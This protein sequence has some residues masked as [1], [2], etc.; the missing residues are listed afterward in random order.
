MSNYRRDFTE[1]AM[2]FFTIVLLDRKSTL[3]TDFVGDF[4]EAY[5]EVQSYYPFETIAIVVLPD[6][7]HVIMQLPEGDSNYSRRIGAIKTN[8]SRRIQNRTD[9]T[10]SQLKK[11][12]SGI[13]QR[14]FWEHLI[15]DDRDLNNHIDYIYYNPVK[16]GYVAKVSDWEYSSFHRDVRLGFFDE[17]WGGDICHEI[18]C[19]DFE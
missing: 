3:L 7:F 12:E 6:H 18:S 13:W 9:K 11:R 8:F 17:D 10:A 19:L 15:R 16:H 5:R 14:R 1:G 2:Y 4:R